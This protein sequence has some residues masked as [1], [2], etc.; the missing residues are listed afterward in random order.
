MGMKKIKELE[1]QFIHTKDGPVRNP[2]LYPTDTMTAMRLL[3]QQWQDLDDLRDSKG[4]RQLKDK[5]RYLKFMPL[6]DQGWLLQTSDAADKSREDVFSVLMWSKSG[7]NEYT[8]AING[9]SIEFSGISESLVTLFHTKEVNLHAKEVEGVERDILNLVLKDEVY[10]AYGQTTVSTMI[11]IAFSSRGVG[12][13]LVRESHWREHQALFTE[14]AI[15]YA[16]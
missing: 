1:S 15:F 12:V 10:D 14:N 11:P 5:G 7:E 16:S 3:P 6:H 4:G 13:A 2:A 9:Q 8:L